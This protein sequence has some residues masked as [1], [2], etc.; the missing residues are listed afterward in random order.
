MKQT[1]RDAEGGSGS[2]K[3][4]G[5]ASVADSG[6]NELYHMHSFHRSCNISGSKM[7]PLL[8]EVGKCAVQ[9]DE[10][11]IG[12]T[13]TEVAKECVHEVMCV[14]RP[15]LIGGWTLARRFLEIR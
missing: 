1:G 13:G 5:G 10:Y 2:E 7:L 8:W 3:Q 14:A 12:M 6:K 11:K 9:V 15:S 4:E